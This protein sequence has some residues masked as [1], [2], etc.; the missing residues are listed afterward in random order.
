MMHTWMPPELPL[1]VK[2]QDVGFTIKHL[3][4]HSNSGVASGGDLAWDVHGS[5]LQL[6]ESMV[7]LKNMLEG[8]SLI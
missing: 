6:P 1:T 7:G 4:S 8:G 5:G 3:L 2:H